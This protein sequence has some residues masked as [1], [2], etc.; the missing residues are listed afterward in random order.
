MRTVI[1]PMVFKAFRRATFAHT[2]QRSGPF[3]HLFRWTAEVLGAF[4][5]LCPL[6]PLRGKAGVSQSENSTIV[7]GRLRF[8][9]RW[10]LDTIS[11]SAYII[12]S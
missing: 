2:R 4:S 6:K 10:R 7:P 11:L 3:S 5:S 9:R 8:V 1:E 12:K